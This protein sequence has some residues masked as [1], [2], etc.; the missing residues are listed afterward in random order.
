[1]KVFVTGATGYLGFNIAS[2]FRR[3]GHRVWGLI[4]NEEKAPV[5]VR[6]EIIPVKGFMQ[7]PGSYSSVAAD[8]SVFVHVASDSQGDTA[9]LD[10][11][12]IDTL[13]ASGT[14]G[15]TPKA[16]IY[17][18]G[19]WGYGNTG[20]ALVDETAPQNPARMVSWRPGHEQIVLNAKEVKGLVIRPGCVYGRQGRLTNMW[21]DSAVNEQSLKIVGDGNNR[22]AMVHVDDLAEGYVAAA[23]SGMSGE[24]FNLNDR[25]RSTVREMAEAVAKVAGY[26]GEIKC[27]PIKDASATMGD[28]AEALALD[29]NVD[30]GKAVRLLGW[31]PKHT[32]FVD[33][34]K[35]YFESWKSSRN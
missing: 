34:I 26:K 33:E 7:E 2:A 31:F 15:A 19:A 28:F 14:K 32:G 18:S 23:E 13:I 11:K 30:N 9:G 6:N 12:T 22:W 3:A 17:T 1:M 5:L 35:T 25:S 10:L 24:I 16:L 27:I 4:R 8:C 29:Q 20:H 21:F